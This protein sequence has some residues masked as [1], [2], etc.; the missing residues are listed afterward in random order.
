MSG[1]HLVPAR[2][3][4]VHDCSTSPFPLQAEL[5]FEEGEDQTLTVR[6]IQTSIEE[7][8]IDVLASVVGQ[9]NTDSVNG[10]SAN[11][12]L[13]AQA[14]NSVATCDV[15]IS[16]DD[17][18]TEV[19]AIAAAGA[20]VRAIACAGDGTSAA[21]TILSR[22]VATAVAQAV[23]Q[24]DTFCEST[25]GP[26]TVACGLSQGTVTAVARAS[27]SAF[28]SGLVEASGDDC[29]CDLSVVADAEAI[30][31]IMATASASGL[32]EVCTGAISRH[33]PPRLRGCTPALH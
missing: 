22:E 32:A 6:D 17:I 23:V 31:E 1:H 13:V 25:G 29:T 5:S 9:I 15:S 12:D 7:T 11:A 3:C 24:A 14:G 10:C 4:A 33:A 8:I 26:G 20:A 21:I 19:N 16:A 28:A 18:L 2:C 27:A 30:E